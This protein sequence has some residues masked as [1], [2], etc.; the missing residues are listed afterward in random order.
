MK[1]GFAPGKTAVLYSGECR[2]NIVLVW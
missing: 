1:S 2:A